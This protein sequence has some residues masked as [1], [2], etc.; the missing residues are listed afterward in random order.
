MI[1]PSS[2]LEPI[3]IN[4]M[5]NVG[6]KSSI[7]CIQPPGSVNPTT[8]LNWTGQQ[9]NIS[10]LIITNISSNGVLTCIAMDI[11]GNTAS[12]TT[13]ISLDET[14]RRIRYNLPS[15]SYGN[16]V[17][18][19]GAPFSINFSDYESPILSVK[20]CVSN[21]TCSPFRLPRICKFQCNSRGPLSVCR[22]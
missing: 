20:Y 17:K 18:S 4:N 6:P 7:Q 8:T 13:N 14:S 11:F 16:L 5:H 19:Y 3:E 1:L 21:S 9:A 10:N 12:V 15:T 2:V 22:S